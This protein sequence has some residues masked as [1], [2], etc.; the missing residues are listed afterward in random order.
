MYSIWEVHVH[1]NGRIDNNFAV[2]STP[3]GQIPRAPPGAAIL[4]TP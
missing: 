1:T 3:C 4:E 2:E